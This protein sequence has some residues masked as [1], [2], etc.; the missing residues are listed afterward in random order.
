MRSLR[1]RRSST[2]PILKWHK[3]NAQET[4]EAQHTPRADRRRAN[5]SV[6][7]FFC[8]SRLSAKFVSSVPPNPPF[9]S[10][11]CPPPPPLCR[12]LMK[13]RVP[14]AAFKRVYGSGIMVRRIRACV[15]RCESVEIKT[16]K[17]HMRLRAPSESFSTHACM[18]QAQPLREPHTYDHA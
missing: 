4:R 7:L 2:V 11:P 9:V 14:Q 6:V 1:L 16:E 15:C 17:D 18:P 10:S 3:G 12:R 5:T 8:S 13:A